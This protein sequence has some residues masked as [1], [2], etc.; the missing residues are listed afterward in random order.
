VLAGFSLYAI[1][2]GLEIRLAGSVV[3]ISPDGAW[4]EDEATIAARLAV[5]ADCPGGARPAPARLSCALALLAAP[6]RARLAV[7]QGARWLTPLLTPPAR[8]AA[9]R[10]QG[11]IRAA[12]RR[13]DPA[14][15]E[16]LERALA[17]VGGGHTAGE[18]MLL[19]G[20]TALGDAEFCRGLRR[21]PDPSPRWSVVE[22][23]L[24]G[25]LLFAPMDAHD[26]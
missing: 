20:L 24:S 18:A 8:A 16:G 6:I 15:L 26:A 21:L 13:R 5:A 22:A 4:T 2:A 14:A 1:A 7:C 3:W 9:M 11:E 25:L 10:I 17:F 23:R 12:A 19:E